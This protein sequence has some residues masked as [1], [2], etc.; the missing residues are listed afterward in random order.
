MSGPNGPTL[1]HPLHIHGYNWAILKQ[2]SMDERMKNP[3]G[4]WKDRVTASDPAIR[5]VIIIPS[6]GFAVVRFIANN[7]GTAANYYLFCY[8]PNCLRNVL[9]RALAWKVKL[10]NYYC[11][12]M[13]STAGK[14]GHKKMAKRETE[15]KSLWYASS[16]RALG[17]IFLLRFKF[18][19]FSPSERLPPFSN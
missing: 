1:N 8:E 16:G 3:E 4:F 7:P 2:G 17:A 9:G 11:S 12:S 13:K 18:H 10:E 5:D 15:C 6:G 14:Y 19:F